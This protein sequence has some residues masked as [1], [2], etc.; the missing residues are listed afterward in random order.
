MGAGAYPQP[1]VAIEIT[2]RTAFVGGAHEMQGAVLPGAQGNWKC[3][4]I[5]HEETTPPGDRTP[6]TSTGNPTIHAHSTLG[7]VGMIPLDDGEI[8]LTFRSSQPP[9]N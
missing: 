1:Q 3:H 9:K 8:P 2:H 6:V 4:S 5:E 7:G